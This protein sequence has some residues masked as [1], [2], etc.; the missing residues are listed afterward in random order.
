[1]G[2]PSEGSIAVIIGGHKCPFVSIWPAAWTC[3]YDPPTDRWYDNET[4]NHQP[5]MVCEKFITAAGCPCLGPGEIVSRT[6]WLRPQEGAE[7]GN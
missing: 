7:H 3:T 5:V 2:E 1:M 4:W 6:I